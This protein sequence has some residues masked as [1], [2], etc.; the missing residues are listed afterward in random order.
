MI[1]GSGLLT[2]PLTATD[3]DPLP[4]AALAGTVTTTCPAFA[5]FGAAVAPPMVADVVVA[6]PRFVPV[7]VIVS[8]GATVVEDI[9][10]ITGAAAKL[11]V[12]VIGLYI[13]TLALWLVP[14]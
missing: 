10:V 1:I 7:I 9:P 11:A 13:V 3:S 8:P 14:E 4:T 2:T 6:L 5:E 12:S